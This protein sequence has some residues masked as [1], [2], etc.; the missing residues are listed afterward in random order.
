MS[1]RRTF[2]LCDWIELLGDRGS[3]RFGRFRYLHEGMGQS[4]ESIESSE[5]SE[6]SESPSFHLSTS[7][8][9]QFRG[10]C[11]QWSSR[12]QRLVENDIHLDSATV[13]RNTVPYCIRIVPVVSYSSSHSESVALPAHAIVRSVDISPDSARILSGSDDKVI[14]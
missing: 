8:S 12:S 7:P 2:E 11:A 1:V 10:F 5:S 14:R 3:I 9:H 4:I 6:S 13:S